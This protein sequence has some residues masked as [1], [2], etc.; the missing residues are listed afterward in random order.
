MIRKRVTVVILAC[1]FT[2]VFC[3]PAAD[4]FGGTNSMAID[5]PS[6]FTVSCSG[7]SALKL[8]WKKAAVSGYQIYKYS[9]GKY[10]KIK[11]IRSRA[12][13]GW[14][15][16]KTKKNRQYS[17]KIRSFKKVGSKTVFS[18]LSGRI[19]GT[20]WKHSGKVNVKS[21]KIK[22]GSRKMK[23]GTSKKLKVKLTGEKKKKIKNSRCIW[24]SS[25]ERTATVDKK[26][27]VTAKR[28][29]KV[30]IYV[31]TENGKSAK[32]K[33]RVTGGRKAKQIPVLAYH[34]VVSE[35]EKATKYKDNKW[36]IT[37]DRFDQQMRFL[38]DNGYRT[39]S[40][41]EF[42]RWY[43]GEIQLP[44]DSVLITFDDGYDS[45]YSNI[46]PILKKYGSK[47]T[48][49]VM[50]GVLPETH[51]D[52]DSFISCDEI[53]EIQRDYPQLEFQSHSFD[54]HR[55]AADGRG[56]VYHMTYDEMLADCVK[57][58]AKGREYLAYPY[59]H[60]NADYVRAVRDSGF[61]LAFQYGARDYAKRSDTDY[62]IPRIG[63][64]WKNDFEFFKKWFK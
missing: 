54:M 27:R 4:V 30:N 50:D 51:K 36:T 23:A 62:E 7:H 5:P 16:R 31:E 18:R 40:M 26:G 64:N 43:K 35:A 44:A 32:A 11:T 37:V 47:A 53:A 3:I 10:R 13:N 1:I 46:Y 20:S 38:H 8:N 28:A 33:I 61:K 21:I 19:T 41:D 63:I 49:F 2:A 45:V 58:R 24:R 52:G 48:S 57:S 56:I 55:P 14:T 12:A 22:S 25:N 60:H 34:N 17:Y 42:Y 9:K 29:G 15:D 39:L 59:G 6:G